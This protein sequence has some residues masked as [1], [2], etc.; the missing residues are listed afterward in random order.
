MQQGNATLTTI[1]VDMLLTVM[2]YPTLASSV[3]QE[4]DVNPSKNWM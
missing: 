3:T 2:I 4:V 1:K